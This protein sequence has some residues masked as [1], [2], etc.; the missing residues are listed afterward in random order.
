MPILPYRTKGK[1][2]YPV[3]IWRGTYFSEELKEA[4]QIGYKIKPIRGY[5]YSK[6]NLFDGYI[7]HF[8]EKKNIALVPPGLLLKCI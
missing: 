7:N 2:I 6:F 8:Y 1:T 4:I 3:G 5:E